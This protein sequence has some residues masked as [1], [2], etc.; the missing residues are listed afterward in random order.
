MPATDAK[1][2]WDSSWRAES[3]EVDPYLAKRLTAGLADDELVPVD[4]FELD[5]CHRDD[6]A[7]RELR[8]L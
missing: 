6:V 3:S 8:R 5:A 2:P 7:G 4:E 1:V